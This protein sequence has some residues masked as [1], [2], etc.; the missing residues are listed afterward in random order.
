MLWWEVKTMR[1]GIS[2]YPWWAIITL[3]LLL[4]V[5]SA[6]SDDDI[7]SLP[8]ASGGG[9]GFPISA[10]DG[11]GIPEMRNSPTFNLASVAS[12]NTINVIF[13]VDTDTTAVSVFVG[14]DVGGTFSIYGSVSNVSVTPGTT[15]TIPVFVTAPSGITVAEVTT[16]NIGLCTLGN[17]GRYYASGDT[18]LIIDLVNFSPIRWTSDVPNTFIVL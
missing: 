4:L 5:V 14:Q 9:G 17:V 12:G 11:D 15:A 16:C 13:D 1:Q 18:Y 8:E 3:G 6:C 7:S 2:K 10:T